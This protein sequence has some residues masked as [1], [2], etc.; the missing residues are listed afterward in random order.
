MAMSA[1]LRDAATQMNALQLQLHEHALR[2]STQLSSQLAPLID[3]LRSHELVQPL[4]TRMQP[5]LARFHTLDAAQQRVAMFMCGGLAFSSML[6]MNSRRRRAAAVDDTVVPAFHKLISQKSGHLKPR[7]T[8]S[9]TGRA[10]IHQV[11]LTGGP[12]GGKA[13]LA[14]RLRTVLRQRGYDVVIAPSVVALLGNAGVEIPAEGAPLLEFETAV[15]QLQLALET[16]FKRAAGAG[17][18]GGKVV[19]LYDRGILDPAAFVP[20]EQW[21]ALASMAPRI[22]RPLDWYTAVVH[23][24]TA[25]DGAPEAFDAAHRGASKA[26][27][28]ASRNLALTI[29]RAVG[30]L[31]ASHPSY[32]RIENRPGGS[33]ED[34]LRRAVE[35]VLSRLEPAG[36]NA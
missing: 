17:A 19:V 3:K 20:R 29:D 7:A 15:F 36:P 28:Q 11:V 5:L 32:V 13:T 18:N 31:Q 33:F 16:S 4:L 30:E 1:R 8:R 9:T 34:K 6:L 25:A 22:E 2:L 35:A 26:S 14:A 10:S 23:L 27:R 21:A 24:V 12:V